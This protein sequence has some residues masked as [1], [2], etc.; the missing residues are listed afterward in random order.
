MTN[1]IKKESIKSLN[2]QALKIKQSEVAKIYRQKGK[3]T[4]LP[5]KILTNKIVLE[6][7]RVKQEVDKIQ[8]LKNEGELVT[9][10]YIEALLKQGQK[11]ITLQKIYKELTKTV[12]ADALL[13]DV[14]TDIQQSFRN[15][16][17]EALKTSYNT[18][19]TAVAERNN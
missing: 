19:K 6:D 17:F 10:D 15:K 12:D 7:L 8:E 9:D 13:Q 16:V 3:K 1:N 5:N 18:V 2:T 4:V 14:E 11:E